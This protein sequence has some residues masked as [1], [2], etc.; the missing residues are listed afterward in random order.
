MKI[1]YLIKTLETGGAEAMVPRVIRV[2]RACG[3]EVQVLAIEPGDRGSTPGLDAL[4]IPYRFLFPH[5]RWNKAAVA[6]ALL[7]AFRRDRPDVIWT[8]LT[9]ATVLGSLVGARLDIPVISWKHSATIKV[10]VRLVRNMS[11]L[12]VTD[13]RSVTR[14]MVENVGLPSEKVM[15]WPIY[16]SAAYAAQPPIYRAGDVLRI[17]SVG[18]L[19]P[20]KNY[21]QLVAAIAQLQLER[22]DLAGRIQVTIAGEGAQRLALEHAIAHAGLEAVMHLQGATDD[23]PAFLA[24]L[25]LYV[26]PSHYEGMC[27]AVHEAM[28][29]GLPILATPVGEVRESLQVSGGGVLLDPADV[30]GSLARAIAALLDHPERLRAMGERGRAYVQA[31]YSPEAFAAAGARVVQRVEGIVRDWPSRGGR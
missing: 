29:A 3:H 9:V 27:L 2:M 13:S 28:S 21:E 6:W 5:R 22:P 14:Y 23:V 17:G 25:H 19:M 1:T 11:Q 16:E 15:E 4:Q 31:T 24:T 18:R 8:S 26:Q 20:Q 10:G 7:R 12:W 30:A